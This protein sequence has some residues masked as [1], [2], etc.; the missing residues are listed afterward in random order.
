MSDTHKN[1]SAHG[2]SEDVI[3]ELPYLLKK[4]AMVIVGDGRISVIPGRMVETARE[5]AAPLLIGIDPNGNV[6]GKNAYEIKTMYGREGFADW[7][8]LRAS[9]S[10][11][12]AGDENK[13]AALLRD[14][15]IKI[16]E[17][18]AYATDLTSGILAQS[19]KRVKPRKGLRPEDAFVL[20]NELSTQEVAHPRQYGETNEQSETDRLAAEFRQNSPE[21]WELQKAEYESEQEEALAEEAERQHR[22]DVRQEMMKYRFLNRTGRFRENIMTPIWATMARTTRTAQFISAIFRGGF[23]TL[24]RWTSTA[25]L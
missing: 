10:R 21:N 2:I 16:T 11:I 19:E 5:K 18:V 4:P 24:K 12:L 17:P 7:L 23:L 13:A 22:D 20:E 15:G 9:D 25:I 1:Y 8:A 3:R 14:V 6:D